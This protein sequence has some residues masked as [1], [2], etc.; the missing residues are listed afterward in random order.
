MN[1]TMIVPYYKPEITAIVPLM[2]DLA[3]D[4]SKYGAHVTVI[5]GFPFRGTSR[6]VRKQYLNKAEEQVE[7]QVRV[8]RVGSKREEGNRFL[9]RAFWHLAKTVA[10]YRMAL[11]VPADVCFI[12]STPPVM[13]LMGALLSKRLPTL[14]CLQ[15]IFPD[16]LT[17]QGKLSKTGA[18]YRMLRKM[19]DYIY[20]NNSCIVTISEEMKQTLIHKKVDEKKVAVI[21]NWVDTDEIRYVAREQNPLF[22]E[23]G[24]DRDAF[25]VTYCGNL[26]YAQDLDL[27]LESAKLTAIKEPEIQ[28]LIV[29]NG[30][31]ETSVYKKITDEGISNV[32]LFP[33]QAE[34]KSAFVYSL[35]SVGLVT[36]KQTMHA[37]AMPSKTWTMM[38]ASLPVI[39]TAEEDT[40][41]YRVVSESGAG[42]LIRPGDHMELADRIIEFYTYKDSLRSYSIRG[43]AYALKHLQ[44][45]TATK[46]YFVRLHE[47]AERRG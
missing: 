22:D 30:A 35:G 12:Y 36:L 7:D 32:K 25:Y 2:D 41:L 5:T 37:Y 33:L 1:V 34:E 46:E 24:L 4:L 31:C 3:H 6:A 18:I 11:R 40:E 17:A 8:L 26:G 19:E 14:Y 29:G 20:R 47:L 10:F 23:F 13:G 42:V 9:Q 39:C 16:N 43:R 44:R 15:D 28:Y 45:K 21:R 38:S 27:I